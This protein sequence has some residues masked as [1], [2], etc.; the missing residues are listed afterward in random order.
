MELLERIDE[1]FQ[2]VAF[3]FQ[4]QIRIAAMAIPQIPASQSPQLLPTSS[5]KAPIVEE[6]DAFLLVVFVPLTGDSESRRSGR[7][8]SLDDLAGFAASHAAFVCLLIP[9]N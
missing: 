6:S 1:F 9:K 8:F 5:A 4:R 2:G 3:D 7:S